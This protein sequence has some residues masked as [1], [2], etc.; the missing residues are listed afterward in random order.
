MHK[1][2][3]KCESILTVGEILKRMRPIQVFPL[4][5]AGCT[6]Y[7]QPHRLAGTAGLNRKVVCKPITCDVSDFFLCVP[8]GFEYPGGKNVF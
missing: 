3:K 1:M 5:V 2:K 8:Q 6:T 4:A 7:K